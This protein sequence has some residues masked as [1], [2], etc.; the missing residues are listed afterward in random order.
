[1]RTIFRMSRG[2]LRITDAI[3]DRW[4]QD[5]EPWTSGKIAMILKALSIFLCPND[6]KF[7]SISLCKIYF[8]IFSDVNEIFLRLT[9]GGVKGNKKQAMNK[10]GA[11]SCNI[12]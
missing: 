12:W 11:S 7:W 6:L 4:Q 2:R 5:S 10:A 1:M 8:Q 3:F 9:S